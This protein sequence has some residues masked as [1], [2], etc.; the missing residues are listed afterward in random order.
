MCACGGSLQL[1]TP[2]KKDGTPKTPSA[3]SLFVKEQ[4]ASVKKENP[5]ATQAEVMKL[6]SSKWKEQK[7][8]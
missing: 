8:V 1:K 4:F 3:Y 6:L 2:L 7:N 5:Y